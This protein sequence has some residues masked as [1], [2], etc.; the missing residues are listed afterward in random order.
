MPRW[1]AHVQRPDKAPISF[2]STN[3]SG[4]IWAVVW[5]L[6]TYSPLSAA[7]HAILAVRPVKVRTHVDVLPPCVRR[8]GSGAVWFSA[9]RALSSDG[10]CAAGRVPGVRGL[11]PRQPDWLACGTG[12]AAAPGRRAGAPRGGHRR[13]LRRCEQGPRPP[14]CWLW[15]RPRCRST[16]PR[17]ALRVPSTL[18]AD[19]RAG[20]CSYDAL[21]HIY[22]LATGPAEFT[23]PT[24]SFRCA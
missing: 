15:R 6:M 13:R 11:F 5:W 16:A 4:A 24:Y 2:M 17:R 20:K 8:G 22:G 10:W 19:G 23:V 14:A 3:R 18:H 12:G 21:H 7:L 9:P 1:P